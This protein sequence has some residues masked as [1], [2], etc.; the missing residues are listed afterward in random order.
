MYLKSNGACF[1]TEL[2]ITTGTGLKWTDFVVH[3]CNSI[4]VVV[5]VLTNRR[6]IYLGHAFHFFLYSVVYVTFSAI[7][8]LAGGTVDGNHYVYWF[9]NWEKP[10]IVAI[11]V[12]LFGVVA[13]VFQCI[14]IGLIRVRDMLR[15]TCREEYREESHL[16]GEVKVRK[17]KKLV[18]TL[19]DQV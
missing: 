1:E 15:K 12:P 2:F 19:S 4:Y 8:Y 17:G 13:V 14:L 11:S 10:Y 7:F 6:P 16:G 18:Y 5:E 9:L 3:G